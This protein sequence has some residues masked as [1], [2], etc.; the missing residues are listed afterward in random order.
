LGRLAG[1]GVAI[2]RLVDELDDR[3]RLL[4]GGSRAGLARHRTLLA[5]VEWSYELLDPGERVLLHRLGVFAGGWTVEAARQVAGFAPLDPAE[6][7]DLLGRLVDKSLAQLD[8]SGRYWLLETIRA[9]ARARAAEAGETSTVAG[10]HLAWA[11][12]FAQRLEK[13]V[14]RA[15]PECLDLVERELPNIRAALDHAADARDPDH[16]GLRL[17]IALAFFAF[18][19]PL[20]TKL[21]P[22]QQAAAA[23]VRARFADPFPVFNPPGDETA[24]TAA[25]CTLTL[26]CS[27]GDGHP[28]RRRLPRAR[29]HRLDR[30]RLRAPPVTMQA[31]S[32]K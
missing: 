7:L 18:A 22:A 12:G 19:D 2:D 32:G 17:M 26:L 15:D 21:N 29:Q 11:A 23:A 3:F 20:F 25:I 6:V 31:G 1:R 13:D 28:L 30:I 9:Y 16:N 14:E 24:E 5:S 27:Q 4:T 10:H 8:D